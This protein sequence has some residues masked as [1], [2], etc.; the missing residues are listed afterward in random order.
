MN[1]EQHIEHKHFFWSYHFYVLV[2]AIYGII[3]AFFL[4]SLSSTV[5]SIIGAV[6]GVIMFVASIIAL[7]YFK[8]LPKITR[9]LP[10]G[11]FVMYGISLIITVA[12][13]VLLL[14]KKD[15]TEVTQ[16]SVII[17]FIFNLFR[18]LFSAYILY[19]FRK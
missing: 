14:Q 6:L 13:T 4:K 7:S 12:L 11:Q 8:N 10:I 5:F 2:L 17:T 1:K 15:T 9:V 16:I 18:L 3:G 19:L